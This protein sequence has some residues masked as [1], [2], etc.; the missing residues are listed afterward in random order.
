MP[1]RSKGWLKIV[2]FVL[3]ACTASAYPGLG[4]DSKPVHDVAVTNVSVPSSCASG[5]TIPVTI[6]LANQGTRRETFSVT[7]TDTNSGKEIASQEVA[8]S[9]GWKDGSEDV[10]DLTFTGETGGPMEFGG[11]VYTGDVNGDSYDDVLV[12]GASRWDGKSEKGRMCLYYGGPDMDNIADKTFAGEADGDRFG[13]HAC[14]GDLEVTGEATYSA[15][16]ADLAHG[17]FNHDDYGDILA[18]ACGYG[19]NDGGSYIV[20]GGAQG[21]MNKATDHTLEGESGMIGRFGFAVESGDVN[22]DGC[23]DI[24]VGAWSYNKSQGRAYLYYGPFESS[25]GITFNWDTTNASPGKH[26]Q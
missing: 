24:V 15:L 10:A 9:K 7:L 20:H 5:D 22:G 21:A 14:I 18:G 16:G 19:R 1:I 8:L 25:T 3:A 23:D 12:A 2:Y 17:E 26:T 13:E 4:S 11:Y 6:S